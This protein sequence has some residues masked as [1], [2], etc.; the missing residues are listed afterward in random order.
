MLNRLKVS[1]QGYVRLFSTHFA[2]ILG[3]RFLASDVINGESRG[4]DSEGG[5]GRFKPNFKMHVP[6][7]NFVAKNSVVCSA[8]MRTYV[9]SDRCAT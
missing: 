8:S 5:L 2:R 6:I 7:S 4:E 9:S 3:T 1:F